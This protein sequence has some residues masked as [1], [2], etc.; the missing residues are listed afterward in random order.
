MMPY[1]SALFVHR[2]IMSSSSKVS[3]RVSTAAEG[4]DR[5]LKRPV[6]CGEDQPR[7]D[8]DDRPAESD[9]S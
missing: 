1:P 4:Y 5:A 2:Y 9:H 8:L 3:N 6:E 7:P